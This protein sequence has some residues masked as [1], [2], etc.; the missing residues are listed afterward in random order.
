MCWKR[1]N[2]ARSGTA[3]L[4]V[5]FIVMA[6]TILSVGFLSRSDVELSCGENM[7]LK[8]QMD[9]LAESGLVHARG[10]IL[11][12]QDAASEYWTGAAEQQ[13]SSGDDYYDVNVVKLDKCNYQISCDA[14][15]LKDSQ[16]VGRSSLEAELRLDPCIAYWA[17]SSTVISERITINGD[18]YC[19]GDLSNNGD[20]HGDVFAAGAIAGTNI[21]GRQNASVTEAP[22]EW[23]G[24]E[25]NDYSWGYYVDSSSYSVQV[26]DPN[27]GSFGPSASNPGG[28][29]YH[30]GDLELAGNVNINGMLVVSGDLM[31]NGANNIISSVKNFPALLVGGEVVVEDGATLEVTGLA[32]IGQ[33]LSIN[34]TASNVEVDILG[35]LYIA[36]GGI[37]G[38]DSSLVSIDIMAGPALSAIETWPVANLPAR[39]SPAGGAFF[40]SIERK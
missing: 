20:I 14:Y 31:V 5:L 32:Q 21:D 15:R 33:R 24:L 18:V 37:E 26:I 3:L 11:N 34:C 39:W 17:G 30:S 22:V 29:R 28:V 27:G 38:A 36:N 23:P 7:I 9:Y 6:V 8:S 35:G 13:I 12:P 25:V 10:L 16:E 19:N 2:I 4:V 40:R 1:N